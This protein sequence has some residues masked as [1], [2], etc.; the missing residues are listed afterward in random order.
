MRSLLGVLMLETR[1][2]RP[3]GDIGNP[4]SFAHPVR[5]K[6][7]RGASPERVVRER[8]AGLLRPF[9]DAARELVDEGCTSITTSC[10]FL[11][12]FQ[13]QLAAALP[14]PVMTSSLLQIAAIEKN[15]APGKRVG[16][17]TIDSKSM[18][19]EHLIAAGARADTPVEGTESGVEFTRRILGN[20]MTLDVERARKDV[21]EAALRLTAR[22]PEV[23]ALVLECTN[24]PPYASA[25]RLATGLPVYDVL[26][27]I[28][29]VH[30]I[31]SDLKLPKPLV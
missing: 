12:L 7:V 8:A 1:F 27:A 6:I 5:Y 11:V 23:A 14:V 26:T 20:E 3:I 25:V 9:I 15:L 29:A 21:V 22:H 18:T 28:A 24:M 30:L 4:A 2:P 31:D 17:L 19:D 16:V 10:G 13:E